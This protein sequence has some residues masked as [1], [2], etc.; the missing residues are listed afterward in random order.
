MSLFIH[1]VLSWRINILAACRNGPAEADN[2]GILRLLQVQDP[3][4]VLPPSTV[5]GSR[6]KGT[7]FELL[8]LTI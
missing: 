2:L 7:K 6:R 1:A 8:V 4:R 3:T 5:D